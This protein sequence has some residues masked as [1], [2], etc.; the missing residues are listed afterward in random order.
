MSSESENQPE[1]LCGTTAMQKRIMSNSNLAEYNPNPQ[2]FLPPNDAD[3]M[4][5]NPTAWFQRRGSDKLSG[6][7][8]GTQG[9]KLVIAMVGLPARGKT[10]I[11]HKLK[12]TC[13]SFR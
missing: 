1:G 11:A 9:D 10:Y 8:H 13:L 7:Q 2:Q 4:Y 3:V 5:P 12:V 6:I